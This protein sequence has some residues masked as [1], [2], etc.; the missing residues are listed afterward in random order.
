MNIQN[1]VVLT[2]ANIAFLKEI[3]KKDKEKVRTSV[4]T[5][6]KAPAWSGMC[7]KSERPK[8]KISHA[9]RRARRVA[10]SYASDPKNKRK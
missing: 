2:K 8:H 4:S 3:Q 5:P 9:E 10:A 7:A 1:G 6:A